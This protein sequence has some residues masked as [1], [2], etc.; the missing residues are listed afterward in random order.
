MPMVVGVEDGVAMGP[1]KTLALKPAHAALH[2]RMGMPDFDEACR[3]R[4][5]DFRSSQTWPH[6]AVSLS[7][8][9]P[10]THC[11]ATLTEIRER[12]SRSRV[13]RRR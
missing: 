4:A 12:T 2:L 7:T 13:R 9:A 3:R 8:I 5:V 6:A 11:G 10:C 1:E